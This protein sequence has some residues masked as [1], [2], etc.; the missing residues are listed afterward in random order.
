VL[1]AELPA[2]ADQEPVETVAADGAGPAF[3]ERVCLRRPKRGADDFDAL[4]FEE[5]VE[6]AGELPVTVVDQEPGRRVARSESDQASCRACWVVR[7]SDSSQAR[8]RNARGGPRF[9]AGAGRATGNAVCGPTI[10]ADPHG[11][12]SRQRLGEVGSRGEEAS[13]LN[14]SATYPSRD[15]ET[16]FTPESGPRGRVGSSG[17]SWSR[18]AALSRT[19][20]WRRRRRT[21]RTCPRAGGSPRSTACARSPWP[22]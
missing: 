5:P 19:R 17:F 14:S 3:G 1:G 15:C 9:R 22:R 16:A 10:K 12:S 20:R 2:A 7:F 18:R 8:A 4:A 13:P 21:R 11:V 6:G